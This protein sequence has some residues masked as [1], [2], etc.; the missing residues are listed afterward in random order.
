MIYFMLGRRVLLLTVAALLMLA[1]VP[2][3]AQDTPADFDAAMMFMQ[4]GSSDFTEIQTVANAMG[5]VEVIVGVNAPSADENAAAFNAAADSLQAAFIGHNAVMLHRYEYIPFVVLELDAAA[6]NVAAAS[7]MVSGMQLNALYAPAMDTSVV[8]IGAD[9]P[10]GAWSMGMDGS[11]WTVAVLDTGVDFKHDALADRIVSQACYSRAVSSY[12]YYTS[13]SACPK[14]V[15][16]SVAP[17]SARYCA[18][19]YQG[20][21]HGTHVAGT[22]VSEDDTYT[23]VAPAANLIAIQV[24]SEVDSAFYCSTGKCPLSFV[25]DQVKGLERVFALRNQ[26]RIAAINMSLGGGEYSSQSACDSDQSNTATKA[27]IDKL[28]RNGIATVIASGN[29]GYTSAMGA[30]GCIS[31]AV[32]VG[33]VDGSDSVASFSNSASFLDLLA[34]GVSITSAE[35]K[36]TFGTKQGT[37]M[38]TPHVAG[39][40]ALLKQADPTL[41][42]DEALDILKETGVSVT[43]DRFGAGNRATSRIQINDA[44]NASAY[45]L[46]EI[47]T[48][49][50]F[51]SMTGDKTTGGWKVKGVGAVKCDKPGKTFAYEGQCAYMLKGDAKNGRL[52][53][54]S[55]GSMRDF[56]AGNVLTLS[57][58]LDGRSNGTKGSVKVVVKYSDGTTKTVEKLG[59]APTDGYQLFTTSATLDSANVDK[60]K[61]QV[62]SSTRSGKLFV[63]AVSMIWEQAPALSAGLLPVPP[64]P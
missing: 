35:P 2:L 63:D 26:Y 22:M 29:D 4:R 8:Q 23:G 40:W 61:L 25:S 21:D 14:G 51:E 47:V 28:K 9:G 36:N 13:K 12:P 11:G 17:K 10:G 52:I 16:E 55:P 48:N 19:S 49:G 7:P 34:P 41:T 50:S 45:S 57:Y 24:F 27:I 32:S 6:L 44:I 58:Q 37:S 5:K 31:S 62:K 3:G 1:V 53:W 43:D 46:S 60:I 18:L 64:A 30:P 54:A 33:A 56:A 38:A 42:V 39:A 15:R 20:C 59:L